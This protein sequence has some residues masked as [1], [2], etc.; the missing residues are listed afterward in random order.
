M[1]GLVALV[2]PMRRLGLH[3]TF[4]PINTG[5]N[6]IE[7]DSLQSVPIC[8]QSQ[9][10]SKVSAICR[11]DKNIAGAY[12]NL[13]NLKTIARSLASMWHGMWLLLTAEVRRT[14]LDTPYCP[15]FE[16]K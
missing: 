10:S 15:L 3:A 16:A 4:S 13:Y 9:A 2:M 11:V 8:A 5:D 7:R 6:Q 14:A 1:Q 12:D